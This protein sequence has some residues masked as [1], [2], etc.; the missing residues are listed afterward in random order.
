[1]TSGKPSSP[2]MATRLARPSGRC[3]FSAGC[4][5][6]RS[7]SALKR[8][9]SSARSMASGEV[10]RIGTLGLLQRLRELQR[11]LAAELHDDA[12]DLA[13]RL[14]GAHDLQHVLCGQRLEIEP[15]GGV[16][17]GRHRLRIAVDHDGLVARVRQREGGVAAAIVELDALADAVRAAA[18]DDDLLAC[19]T[20]APRIAAVRRSRTRRSNTCRRWARRTRPRRCRCACRPG[21]RRAPGASRRPRSPRAP[22][23]LASRA[24]E[25]PMA[26][27]ARKL[28]ASCGRPCARTRAS[29]STISLIWREEP[30]V[31][32]AGLVDL[33]VDRSRAG[34]PAPP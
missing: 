17:V 30:R 34:A 4:R 27:S 18:E 32:L 2:A 26:F 3:R 22:A 20:A 21:A 7:I 1:M 15:V 6:S 12:L 5:P 11:R 10:P 23:S 9:R 16:V 24:S 14:L 33:L 13:V 28:A 19:P 8:S 25:K 31:D 29:I